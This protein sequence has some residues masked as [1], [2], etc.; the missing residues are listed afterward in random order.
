M[1]KA[2]KGIGECRP[3]LLAVGSHRGKSASYGKADRVSGREVNAGDL[4]RL[5]RHSPALLPT[6]RTSCTLAAAAAVARPLTH[7]PAQALKQTV[8]LEDSGSHFALAEPEDFRAASQ[9][10]QGNTL[11]SESGVEC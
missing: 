3:A 2:V 9:G 8:C 6:P 5:P 7:A 11:Q 1:A 10:T 4:P